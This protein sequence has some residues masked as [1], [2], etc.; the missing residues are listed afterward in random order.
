MTQNVLDIWG[1]I[2]GIVAG[3][4]VLIVF[5]VAIAIK[6][7]PKTLPGSSGHR[8]KGDEESGETIRPDGY[9][10]SF[11]GVIEEAGGGLPPVMRIAIPGILIWWLVTL[12]LYWTPK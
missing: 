7:H 8:E 2:V 5:A 1:E 4:G 3:A 12:I 10:D 9:I 11:A 6:W